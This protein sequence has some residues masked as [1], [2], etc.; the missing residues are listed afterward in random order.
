MDIGL[1]ADEIQSESLNA[2][3]RSSST[4]GGRFSRIGINNVFSSAGTFLIAV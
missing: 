1:I 4:L 2:K 3:R